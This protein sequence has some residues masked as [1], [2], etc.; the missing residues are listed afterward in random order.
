M[1]LKFVYDPEAD[2]GFLKVGEGP[3]VETEPAT[4]NINLDFNAKGELVSIEIL[5][6]SRSAPG[7]LAKPFKAVAAE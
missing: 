2:A 1:S 5:N 3:S 4:D 6:V 7:L